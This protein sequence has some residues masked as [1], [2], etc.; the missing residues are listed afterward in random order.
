MSVKIMSA[1]FEAQIPD[2]VYVDK[3]GKK[4]TVK[5]STL[6][7]VLLALSDHASDTGES[8][9][10]SIEYLRRKTSIGSPNTCVAAIGALESLGILKHVGNR[11]RGNKEYRITLSVISELHPVQSTITPSVNESSLTIN[12][13]SVA[14]SKEE[15]AYAPRKVVKTY[16]PEEVDKPTKRKIQKPKSNVKL[17]E[18]QTKGERILF[19]LLQSEIVKLHGPGWKVPKRFPSFA[20]KELFA[21]SEER[22][23]GQLSSAINAG[24]QK[25]IRDVGNLV[26]YVNAV[27]E[28]DDREHATNAD[29]LAAGYKL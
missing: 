9:Y 19:G 25:G 29:L 26:K 16:I 24:I 5:S 11:V 2:Q 6:K 4:T 20:C 1:V 8:V 7:L 21:E 10:P 27:R 18:P 12:E 3:K 17:L 15:I 14:I 23:N 28:K 22:L 13:P